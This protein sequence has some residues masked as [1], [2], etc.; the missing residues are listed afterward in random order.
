MAT[1]SLD[2]S[3]A[4]I[5][6]FIPTFVKSIE[7]KVSLKGDLQGFFLDTQHTHCLHSATHREREL[8]YHEA[9]WSIT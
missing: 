7:V 4:A 5:P 8:I 6:T 9:V 3:E 1:S 2:V